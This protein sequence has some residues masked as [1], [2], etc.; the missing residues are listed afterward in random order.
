MKG[1]EEEYELNFSHYTPSRA[2]YD[3][4]AMVS[5][6]AHVIGGGGAGAGELA[7]GEAISSSTDLP[8]EAQ[9]NEKE[10]KRHFRGV[11]QRPWGKWAAE[12]R[13]PNK[14]ARVWLGTFETAEDAA[15]AYDNAALKF[16]GK[17]A[18]LNF[19]EKV[20]NG[21]LFL[22]NRGVISQQSD[23]SSIT[24]SDLALYDSRASTISFASSSQDYF[25]SE[26]M[27]NFG[28]YSSGSST[29]WPKKSYGDKRGKDII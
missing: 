25:T 12:I 4:S 22:N 18:K 26:V 29:S 11:R 17:K 8:S 24:A 20:P 9:G 2:E 6:L 13:D 14:A 23:Q 28:D 16:K 15:M 7:A 1:K 19:P 10:K 3:T 27:L 21:N 5:A